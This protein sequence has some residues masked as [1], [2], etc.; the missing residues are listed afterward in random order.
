MATYPAVWAV[1][2]LFSFCVPCCSIVWRY[3]H[4]RYCPARHTANIRERSLSTSTPLSCPFISTVFLDLENRL[5]CKGLSLPKV[6]LRQL[7]GFH[8]SVVLF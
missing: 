1:L 3:G 5:S 2:D 7:A 8:K 4:R 6:D